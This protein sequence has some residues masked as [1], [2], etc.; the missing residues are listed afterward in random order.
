MPPTTNARI[1]GVEGCEICWNVEAISRTP[2]LAD[3][4]M[5]AQDGCPY[6][7]LLVVVVDTFTPNLHGN[8]DIQFIRHEEIL[9]ILWDEDGR[10]RSA[11][12]YCSPT[13]SG[14]ESRQGELIPNLNIRS[15]LGDTPAGPFFHMIEYFVDQC[16]CGPSSPPYLPTRV[17]DLGEPPA[18]GPVCLI[19]P[20]HGQQPYFVN[21]HTMYV[22]A[23]A[24]VKASSHYGLY[25]QICMR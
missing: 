10:P 16:Q 12:A 2:N 9:E 23:I 1:L 3:S 15:I 6:C 8:A 20:L 4:R 7:Q 25:R 19:Q 13:G 18:A 17:L 21:S 11:S 14:Y 22:L 5:S 24:G